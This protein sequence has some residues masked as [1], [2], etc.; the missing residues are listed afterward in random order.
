MAGKVS[1]R[2]L[3]ITSECGGMVNIHFDELEDNIVK[4]EVVDLPGSF[5]ET[6]KDTK[7]K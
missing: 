7:I 5:K 6:R 3:C 1:K 2:V 4:V